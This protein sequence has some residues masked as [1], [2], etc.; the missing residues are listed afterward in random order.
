MLGYPPSS[1]TAPAEI[2]EVFRMWRILWQGN[3]AGDLDFLLLSYFQRESGSCL[4]V[5]DVG[6]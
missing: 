4:I 1:V 6:D 2:G 5:E 3:C